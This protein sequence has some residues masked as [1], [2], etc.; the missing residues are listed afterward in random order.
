MKNKPFYTAQELADILEVN[1]MTVYRYIKSKKLK[2]YKFSKEFR[3]D[4]QEFDS[5]IKKSKV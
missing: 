5:F 3:I 4:K 1:I 2:A